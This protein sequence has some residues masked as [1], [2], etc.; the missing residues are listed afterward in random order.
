MPELNVSPAPIVLIGSNSFEA[1]C[2]VNLG[3]RRSTPRLLR[4]RIRTGG[5]M[6][7]VFNYFIKTDIGIIFIKNELKIFIGSSDDIGE[8]HVFQNKRL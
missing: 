2:R 7:L 5:T 3:V 8:S 4:V 6:C 1:K